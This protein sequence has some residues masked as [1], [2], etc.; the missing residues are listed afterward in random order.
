MLCVGWGKDIPVVQN[1]SNT[2]LSAR[3]EKSIPALIINVFGDMT[4]SISILG[5]YSIPG[6]DF[7]PITRPK[8]LAQYFT[9][10]HCP[11]QIP[12]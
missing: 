12:R 1:T 2:Q 6:I 8:I 11:K 10:N 5:S 3:D 4:D 9:P 7:S